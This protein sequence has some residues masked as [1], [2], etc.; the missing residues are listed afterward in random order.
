[1][2][3][4]LTTALPMLWM[5][6]PQTDVEFAAHHVGGNVFVGDVL[7]V[8]QLNNGNAQSLSQRLQKRNIRQ[9]LCR[10]PFGDGLAADADLFSQLCLRQIPVFPQLPDGV[11]GNVSIHRCH[12]LSF[13]AY[14]EK[15]ASATYAP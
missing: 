13:T 3:Q 12:F 4:Q 5:A 10:L 11:S 15:P 9:T 8:H 2:P 6:L 7:P 1:M 14:H